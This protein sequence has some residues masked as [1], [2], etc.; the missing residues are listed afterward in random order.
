MSFSYAFL[1]V[2]L[3]CAECHKHPFDQWT[4]EDFD[5][6]TAFFEPVVYA[7][8][9]QTRSQYQQMLATIVGDAKGGMA[10]RKLAETL[11]GGATVPWREVF[12]AGN[13]RPNNPARGKNNKNKS[14][15]RGASRRVVTPKVLGEDESVD[16][17]RGEDLRTALMQW[18]RTR[19][20]LFRPFVRQSRLGVILQRRHH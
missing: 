8:T 7:N 2:R 11:K 3:Q 5:Q 10:Q 15:N 14:K 9:P 20:S 17:A 4:K 6:F 1:G 19:Q 16:L 13:N 18:M 12:V